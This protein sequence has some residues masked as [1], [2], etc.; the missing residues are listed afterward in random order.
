M[1]I[2]ITV[3][4]RQT[5]IHLMIRVVILVLRHMSPVVILVIVV[6]A[7]LQV[8]TILVVSVE[9]VVVLFKLINKLIYKSDCNSLLYIYI[10]IY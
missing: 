5:T 4:V 1:K 9:I 6:A 8:M 2:Q 3:T 10:L 7:H